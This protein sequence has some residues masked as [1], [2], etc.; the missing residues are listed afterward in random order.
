[1]IKHKS[2]DEF[3]ELGAFK[4]QN[5]EKILAFKFSIFIGAGNEEESEEEPSNAVDQTQPPKNNK[6]G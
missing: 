2:P 4:F 5:I 6:P 1:M 3:Y